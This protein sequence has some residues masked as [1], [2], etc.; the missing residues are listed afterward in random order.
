MYFMHTQHSDE[1]SRPKYANC[2]QKLAHKAPFIFGLFSE[3]RLRNARPCPREALSDQQ[4]AKLYDSSGMVVADCVTVKE[5]V[6]VRVDV[7]ELV[8]VTD[9]GTEEVELVD[10]MVKEVDPDV[11][12]D[13]RVVVEDVTA[14]EDVL[15]GIITTEPFSSVVILS[16]Q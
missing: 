5:E 14:M 13:G 2:E 8:G 7:I 16:L 6:A 12:V 15:E 1:F 9:A 4:P 3:G 10:E 11:V